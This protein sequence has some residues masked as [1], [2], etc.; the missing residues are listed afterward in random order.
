VAQSADEQLLVS[1][2]PWYIANGTS[3]MKKESLKMSSTGTIMVIG[4]NIFN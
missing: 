3:R 1:L 4:L 2:V